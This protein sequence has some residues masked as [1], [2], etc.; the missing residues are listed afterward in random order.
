MTTA[1]LNLTAEATK[2]EDR[3]AAI[4][5]TLD[6][7]SHNDFLVMTSDFA[8]GLYMTEIDGKWFAR[9]AAVA[10]RM[11][12]RMA[13]ALAASALRTWPDAKPFRAVDAL[14]AEAAQLREVAAQFRA[15]S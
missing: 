12:E 14:R 9:G 8:G 2:L 6:T 11:T 13:R 15:V 3:A 7:V 5:A 10:Q 1:A 4:E